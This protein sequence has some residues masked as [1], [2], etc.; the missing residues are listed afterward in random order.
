[1]AAALLRGTIKEALFAMLKYLWKDYSA[2]YTLS[3]DLQYCRRITSF[4]PLKLDVAGG[5]LERQIDL[6]N[7]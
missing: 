6:V 5:I 4:I 2:P 3:S 7:D 1:V